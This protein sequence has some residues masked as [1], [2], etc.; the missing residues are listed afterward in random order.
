MA[1]KLIEIGSVKGGGMIID[2]YGSFGLSAFAEAKKPQS[3]ADFQGAETRMAA[4]GYGEGVAYMK[5]LTKDNVTLV[6]PSG[7]KVLSQTYEIRLFDASGKDVTDRECG[8]CKPVKR[9]V[10]FKGSQ[11]YL[12][13]TPFMTDALE[14][15][16]IQSIEY[17]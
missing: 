17:K 11:N 15:K 5:E 6:L 13:L 10:L 9:Y 7:V 8:D 12:A 16:I 4:R 3:L 1:K 2:T 14:T